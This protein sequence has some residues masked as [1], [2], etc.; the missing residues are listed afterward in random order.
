MLIA[1]GAT[2]SRLS[3][4]DTNEN[5]RNVTIRMKIDDGLISIWCKHCKSTLLNVHRQN[6]SYLEIFATFTL[7]AFLYGKCPKCFKHL[8]NREFADAF[9]VMCEAR[10][11]VEVIIASLFGSEHV[12]GDPNKALAPHSR[13]TLVNCIL[14]K[15]SYQ[16]YSYNSPVLNSAEIRAAANFMMGTFK[17]TE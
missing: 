13:A 14:K 8:A 7:K 16:R 12:I 9:M 2:K 10:S 17:D 5:L 3:T 11:P 15:Q 4:R 6:I 1:I